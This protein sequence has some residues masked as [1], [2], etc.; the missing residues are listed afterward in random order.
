MGPFS[1]RQRTRVDGLGEASPPRP[2]RQVPGWRPSC[3]L[4]APLGRGG[5]FQP[6]S[7]SPCPPFPVSRGLCTPERRPQLPRLQGS[8]GRPALRLSPAP[9]PPRPAARLHPARCGEPEPAGSPHSGSPCW[10]P[11]AL[12]GRDPGRLCAGRVSESGQEGQ[13]RCVGRMGRRSKTA[14]AAAEDAGRRT[15]RRSRVRITD[16]HS[17]TVPET[18][19][20][21]NDS[22]R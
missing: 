2:G 7:W 18:T 8:A 14:L 1:S 3:G 10:Q 12:P 6:L 19:T 11:A 21:E 4:L 5:L 9:A 13:E 22:L 17:E 20:A 16:R 15:A